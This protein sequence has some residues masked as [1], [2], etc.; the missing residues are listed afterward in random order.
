MEQTRADT[1]TPPQNARMVSALQSSPAR[2][3]VSEFLES[4]ENTDDQTATAIL[5]ELYM[6]GKITKGKCEKYRAHY[7]RLQAAQAKMKANEFLAEARLNRTLNKS[8]AE[9]RKIDESEHGSSKSAHLINM[10]RDQ[11]ATVESELTRWREREGYFERQQKDAEEEKANL[12]AMKEKMEQQ[13]RAERGT[14]TALLM[15]EVESLKQ[16]IAAEAAKVTRLTRDRSEFGARAVCLADEHVA[17]KDEVQHL[18]TQLSEKR[19][20]P[21]T[22]KEQSTRYDIELNRLKDQ[23]A[24]L[25]KEKSDLEE[26]RVRA[27][28]AKKEIVKLDVQLKN[29]E[30]REK[31]RSESIDRLFATQGKKIRDEEQ[32]QAQ[33]DEELEGVLKKIQATQ[34]ETQ[35]L[36]DDQINAERM[37]NERL[38]DYRILEQK[39]EEL[40]QSLPAHDSS[41]VDI[42]RQLAALRKQH[43]QAR[44]EREERWWQLKMT[45]AETIKMRDRKKK[46]DDEEKTQK[47]LADS[48]KKSKHDAGREISLQDVVFV[49]ELLQAK[50]QQYQQ[51]DVEFAKAR[52][53]L[54][55]EREMRSAECSKMLCKNREAAERLVMRNQV[56]HQLQLDL[57]AKQTQLAEL[58]RKYEKVK[59]ER[60]SLTDKIQRAVQAVDAHHDRAQLIAAREDILC[61]EKKVAKQ[62]LMEEKKR[63][64]KTIIARI[65]E[66]NNYNR[67]LLEKQAREL[68]IDKIVGQIEE[69]YSQVK[70]ADA[71]MAL[72]LK[73]YEVVVEER[74]YMGIQLIDRNDELCLLHEKVNAQQIILKAADEALMRKDEKLYYIKLEKRD[75]ERQLENHSKQIPTVEHTAAE[76]A[77]V[78]EEIVAQRA[79]V[80]ELSA[81]L[82]NPADPERWHEVG[83]PIPSQTELREREDDLKKKLCKQTDNVLSKNLLLKEFVGAYN[84][85]LQDSEK[86][87]ETRHQTAQQLLEFKHKTEEVNRKLKAMVAELALYKVLAHQQLPAQIQQMEADLAQAREN[88][89]NGKP[90]TAEAALEWN[91]YCERA[92]RDAEAMQL[93]VLED[94]ECTTTTEPRVKTYIDPQFGTKV[95]FF[96]GDPFKPSVRGSTMRHFRNPRNKE[97]VL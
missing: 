54:A 57:N 33:L 73:N 60:G 68:Q 94:E 72:M 6:R 48:I 32:H 45:V 19:V 15:E 18:S 47:D 96:G 1:D 95:P 85:M 84:R 93:D 67:L 34:K 43:A 16:E 31:M 90:P 52:T 58:A 26:A 80:E 2:H 13:E 12:L 24:Q 81:R 41:L 40:V 91:L 56:A 65:N 59:Q 89:A 74:N 20:G 39:V 8:A 38:K 49:P 69:L 88:A 42:D 5:D 11:L 27:V 17:L 7:A 3:R 64:K 55:A 70:K 28:K 22:L 75:L 76:L 46:L 10:L 9:Q 14:T 30:D 83:G 35:R 71:E 21:E 87:K 53:R 86:T 51:K 78:R 62:E 4:K 61:K 82:E 50:L 36:N 23:M 37:N 66:Q 92:Q 44:A 97:I 63:H 77:Q 29:N 25:Q 79:L